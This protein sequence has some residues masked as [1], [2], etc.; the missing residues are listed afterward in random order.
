MRKV[1]IPLALVALAGPAWA[2][3]LSPA[4]AL[5]RALGDAATPA[6]VN[7]MNGLAAK[8]VTPAFT[9]TDK[10]TGTPSLYVITPSDGKD[11]SWFQPMT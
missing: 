8:A 5:D 2:R 1:I 10:T 9:L 4:E 11:S 3:T 7:A 6:R